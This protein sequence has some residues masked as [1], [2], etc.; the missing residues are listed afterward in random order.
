MNNTARQIVLF[1]A[2]GGIS[3]VFNYF[4][5]WIALEVFGVFYLAA[6][7]LGYFAG[8]VLGYVLNA[9][10]TFRAGPGFSGALAAGYAAVYAVSLALSNLTLYGLVHFLNLPPQVANVGAIFQST[11]TNF[12]G[13]KF[14][15]FR[16]K[17]QHD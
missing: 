8:V 4:V 7:V 10:Y 2:A 16:G 17:R 1:L 5:F 14:L 6:N 13:C 15:V 3:T 9:R 12:L 11:V